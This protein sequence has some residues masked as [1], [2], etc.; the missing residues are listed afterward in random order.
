MKKIGKIKK[1]GIALTALS[2]SAALLAGGL[3]CATPYNASA[4]DVTPRTAA[5]A[6]TLFEKLTVPSEAT[7]GTSI[8]VPEAPSGSK[9]VVLAPDNES[10]PLGDATDGFYSVKTN[11]VGIYDVKY[12]SDADDSAA[13]TFR[14][15]VSLDEDYFLKVDNNGATIKTRMGINDSITLPEAHVAYYDEN[16]ILR[17]YPSDKVHWTIKDS[18]GDTDNPTGRTYEFGDKVEA[19]NSGKMYITYSAWIEDK[20]TKHFSQTFEV[21]VQSSFTDKQAPSL[22]VSGITS[23]IS[24]RRAVTLPTATVSDDYDKNPLV[25]ITVTDPDGKPVKVVDIDENGYA[26]Q[27][28]TKL[29]AD[30][31][32]L[33]KP[34]ADRNLGKLNYPNVAF[35]NKDVMTFYPLIPGPYKV[36][37]V[38]RDDAGNVSSSKSW[39]MNAGDSVAPV[40]KNESDWKWKIPAKWGLTVENAESTL[41]NT[42]IQLPIPELVDNKD[43]VPTAED[44]LPSADKDEVAKD[45]ISLYV[46]ITDADYSRDILTFKNVFAKPAAGDATKSDCNADNEVYDGGAKQTFSLFSNVPFEFDFTKYAR[47]DKDGETVDLAGKYTVYYRASDAAGNRSTRTFEIDLQSSYEDKKAPTIDD[48]SVPDY[49]SYADTEFNIPSVVAKDAESSTIRVEYRIYSDNALEDKEGGRYITVDGGEKAAIE[50]RGNDLFLILDKGKAY[51][52]ELKLVD[53]M[54]FCVTAT[55]AVG[56]V[57][58]N[59]ENLD[60]AFTVDNYTESS[61]VVSIISKSKTSNY[62]YNGGIEFK[63][64]TYD[65]SGKNITGWTASDSIMT[66]QKVNAG[67]FTI[68]L[69]DVDMRKYTGFEVSVMHGDS[70]LETELDTYTTY[71]DSN[72]KIYVDNIKF[73][74]SKEGDHYLSVRVFDV[75]DVNS[76]YTYKFNVAKTTDPGS[77]VKPSA[78]VI[79]DSNAAVNVKYTLHETEDNFAGAE[80]GKTYYHAHKIRG[81]VYS[82]MGNEFIAKAQ[83]GYSVTD[84]FVDESKVDS[85]N[86]LGADFLS[87]GVNGGNY[88]FSVTDTIKPVIEIQGI[89]PTYAE[90][91]TDAKPVKVEIPS[92]IAYSANGRADVKIEVT[93]GGNKVNIEKVPDTNKYTF[94]GKKDGVYTI[95]ITATRADAGETTAT[96]DVNIG[97]VIAPE[98]TVSGGTSGRK[99]QGDTFTYGKIKLV[100]ESEKGTVT[101]TKKIYDPSG[102]EVSGA[103]VSGSY[104]SYKDKPNNGSAIKL[105]KSGTYKVVYTVKDAVGNGEDSPLIEYI[106]VSA[107][108]TSTP[109]TFTTLSTVLIIIAVV[110]LAGVIVYVVRFRKVKK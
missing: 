76:V 11:Q 21:N 83:G 9:V 108:G 93:N 59:S 5:T 50:A 103:A 51:A 96:Y 32:E 65:A 82:L 57:A 19:K 15:N 30:A 42:A 13:Y 25:E 107:S 40:F 2:V 73:T 62:T 75:N 90:K 63:T 72:A 6:V 66:G 74:P 31:A 84:G 68:V 88:S 49:V 33:E 45:L 10:V 91:S 41:E 85:Y 34:E 52:K 97:D 39:T 98:F 18:I 92:V 4:D 101:I 71:D 87:D 77:N 24:V 53:K 100:D 89:M 99:S 36:K 38:A 70:A 28:K 61:D 3:A 16:K 26:Y 80:S 37:Y 81:W 20:G 95:K 94:E 109:T 43:R 12:I 8:S 44:N 7:Y 106:T 35:D 105:D 1:S 102:A 55:D 23:N 110:L 60:E 104:N 46:R 54:Y 67:G 64:A 47:K 69:T 86:E 22:T 58:V 14:V 27:D 17:Y 56:N 78:V 29:D 79:P 48:I